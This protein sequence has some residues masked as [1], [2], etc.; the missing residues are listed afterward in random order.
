MT[1]STCTCRRACGI[2][3][4]R[5]QWVANEMQRDSTQLVANDSFSAVFD[6]F[7]DR[8]NGVA[9]MVNP[10]G[11]FFDYEISNEG[12]ANRDWNPIWD[13][14]TGRFDGGWT[15]E[16][17]FHLSPSVLSQAQRK[18]GGCSSRELFMEERTGLSDADPY[19]RWTRRVPS[20][21]GRNA[22]GRRGASG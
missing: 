1:I 12:N 4:Q 13:V 15:T 18:P 10:I 6:T 5:S 3:R 21:G 8:R 7:Y 9:F 2:Q 19:F 14:K 22:D 20:V 16:F 17:R 11:G